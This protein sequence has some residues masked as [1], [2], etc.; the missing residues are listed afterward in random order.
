MADTIL[1]TVF[2][3]ASNIDAE[4]VDIKTALALIDGVVMEMRCGDKDEVIEAQGKLLYL[5]RGLPDKLREIQ[6]ETK[7]LM[8]ECRDLPSEAA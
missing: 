4:A 8:D 3:I 1:P 5:L 2:N 6:L 7:R